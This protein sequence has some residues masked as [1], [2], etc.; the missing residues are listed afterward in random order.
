M[1][2]MYSVSKLNIWSLTYDQVLD[3]NKSNGIFTISLNYHRTADLSKSSSSENIDCIKEERT[4]E[5]M[6]TPDNKLCHNYEKR[7]SCLSSDTKAQ[8]KRH[9]L[10][11]HLCQMENHKTAKIRLPQ[12][13]AFSSNSFRTLNSHKR[14]SKSS[15]RRTQSNSI[16]ELCSC[17]GISS[18]NSTVSSS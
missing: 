5:K 4:S 14:S 8:N 11:N 15:Y 10:C 3:Y 18:D 16:F 2:Q 13:S 1:D 7:Y 6:K 17:L 9:S 12:L